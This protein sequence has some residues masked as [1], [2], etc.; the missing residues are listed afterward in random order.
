MYIEILENGLFIPPKVIPKIV[1]NGVRF[2]QK[3][4][5]KELSEFTDTHKE[6]VA[7]D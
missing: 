5:P 7:L 4:T 6:Y 2:R 3:S 1:E